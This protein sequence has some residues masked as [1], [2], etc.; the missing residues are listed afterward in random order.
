M[1]QTAAQSAFM[2]TTA[3]KFE[4]VNGELQSMLKSLLGEL[5]VLQT[6]WQG[7][8][9]KSFQQVKERWSED[10]E[11]LQRALLA[12]AQAIRESGKNYHTTD[13]EASSNMGSIH[14]SGVSLPL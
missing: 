11:K 2:Q 9:G 5:E 10:Q 8:G 14:S 3:G 1:A 12:T 13:T 6:A 7:A 4:T